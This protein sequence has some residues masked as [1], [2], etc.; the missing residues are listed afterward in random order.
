MECRLRDCAGSVGVGRNGGRRA[1]GSIAGFLDGLLVV[2]GSGGGFAE[3][4]EVVEVEKVLAVLVVVYGAEVVGIVVVE[5]V[6]ARIEAFEG[7]EGFGRA[8]NLAA[9]DVLHAWGAVQQAGH[10][11]VGNGWEHGD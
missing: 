4:D 5:H 6:A 2:V 3:V 8:E 1:G 10:H 7:V 11:K 9:E